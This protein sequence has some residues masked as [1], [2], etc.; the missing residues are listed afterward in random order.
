ME[1][2]DTNPTDSE[3]TQDIEGSHVFLGKHMTSDFR[4]FGQSRGAQSAFVI[5]KHTFSK[6]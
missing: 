2:G 6:R 3:A 5:L 4:L 1:I